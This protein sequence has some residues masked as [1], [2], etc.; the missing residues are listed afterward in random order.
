MESCILS[1]ELC[2][3]IIDGVGTPRA[4]SS[5]DCSWDH[6]AC[7]NRQ[8]TLWACALTCRNWRIRAQMLLWRHPCIWSGPA[9]PLFVAATRR[10]PHYYSRNTVTLHLRP[11]LKDQT[12]VNSL[13]LG[14]TAPHLRDLSWC[15]M[16]F[17]TRGASWVLRMRLP[18]FDSITSLE[19]HRCSFSS[20]RGLLDVIWSV[21]NILSLSMSY[22][23]DF[24]DKTCTDETSARL[25]SACRQR[26]ACQKLKTVKLDL[27][28]F[29]GPY[30]LFGGTVLGTA[31]TDLEVL[32]KD[33]AQA[34]ICP[35]SPSIWLCYRHGAASV[36]ERRQR[37]TRGQERKLKRA[38][39]A[40]DAPCCPAEAEE[41]CN[42]SLHLRTRRS[43]LHLLHGTYW[44][45]GGASRAT[46]EAAP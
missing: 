43:A 42:R 9:F 1:I 12:L 22:C 24:V 21:P 34:R 11:R 26:K 2:E 30:T 27:L 7:H 25:S 38:R 39:Y 17:N 5:W 33:I 31:I 28:Y 18:F 16:Q 41:D 44:K 29:D 13:F 35:L 37:R 14:P 19:L 20:A 4:A 32:F 8:R 45:P 46:G 40:G 15:N 10:L 6:T 36:P 3:A 23:W